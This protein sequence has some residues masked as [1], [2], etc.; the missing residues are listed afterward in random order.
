M[1]ERFIDRNYQRSYAKVDD[2][3]TKWLDIPYMAGNRHQLDIYLPNQTAT[4]Y[5]VIID[6]FGGGLYFGDKSS[7]KL[8]PALR[9]LRQDGFAVVSMD[10]S[11]LH[12]APF[13][14]QIYEVKAV[15][16]YIRANAE[17]YHLNPN[18]IA[19]MGE[20]S[21]AQLAVTTAATHGVNAMEK[22]DFGQY[23]DVS[24]DVQAVIAMY[25]PYE[26][27]KFKEQFAESGVQSKYPETGT[28]IS[29]QGQLFGQRAPK[30][31]P[32]LVEAVNP[33]TYFSPDL[34][35]ML[36]MVGRADPVVPYQQTVNMMA[37]ARDQIGAD[38][39]PYYIIEDGVHGPDD[40]MGEHLT[41][42]K[43]DFLKKWL[44]V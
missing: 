35:P 43:A 8:E 2:I 20:S 6:I 32:E 1:A 31:V 7:H 5:P 24:E 44:E 29:F 10:Y 12:D 37:A 22:L 40:Y 13:P 15:I 39:T 33:V 21:G 27:D 16:R 42:V 17:K 19:L 11:L 38:K 26:F 25:G 41:Q 23:P 34:P 36:A 9:L 3:Q 14:T 28:A 4:T 30:D 18:Q